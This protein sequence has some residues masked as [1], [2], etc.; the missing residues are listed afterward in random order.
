MMKVALR[1]QRGTNLAEASACGHCDQTD[2]SCSSSSSDQ[3]L[4]GHGTC[5][6]KTQPIS[7][8]QTYILVPMVNCNAKVQTKCLQFGYSN[9][10]EI[11]SPPKSSSQKHTHISRD[12]TKTGKG[13]QALHSH[14][15]HAYDSPHVQQY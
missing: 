7:K 4:T 6:T 5:I 11:H 13:K 10:I 15:T 1:R 9:R 14:F 8:N 2:A 12:D 3:T